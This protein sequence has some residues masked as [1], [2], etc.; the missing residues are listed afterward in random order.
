[1]EAGSIIEIPALY[2]ASHAGMMPQP[3]SSVFRYVSMK[4]DDAW[5]FLETTLLTNTLPLAAS[6]IL[7]DPF[8]A[9]PV[10][11]NDT[12]T[13]EIAASIKRFTI[14]QGNADVPI[15][16]DKLQ[17]AGPDGAS[18][19]PEA[20]AKRTQELFEGM[21]AQRNRQ[22]HIASFSRRISSELQWSHYAD[23]HKGIA[24]HFVPTSSTESE[25]KGLKT[26]KYARQR[27]IVFLSELIDQ[28]SIEPTSNKF[29]LSWL[30]YEERSF[31][32]KSTEWSYEE[33]ERVIKQNVGSMSFLE[34]ELMSIIV[35]PR[36]ND[37]NVSRLKAVVAKRRRP[38]K[39]YR[40]APS[41]TDYSIEIKWSDPL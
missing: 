12:T 22:C 7:N 5:S 29:V 18:L 30:S 14:R 17:V 33:E 24:Y 34:S 15:D 11:L 8:E 36:F 2:A 10:I 16:L 31:L 20:L 19:G 38:I 37:E 32:A 40:A 26:V 39:I 9:S 21:I 6:T 41:Q 4:G 13:A 25:F 3:K 28:I 23:G 1:M 35:G 27:P